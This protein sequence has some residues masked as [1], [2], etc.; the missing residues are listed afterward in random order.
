VRIGYLLF[1]APASCV[2]AINLFAGLGKDFH[3][4]EQRVVWVTGAGVAI[5]SA[6]GSIAGGYI[7]DRMNRGVL[8][9]LGGAAAGLC[10]LT[11]AFTL[12]TQAAFTAG[13]LV[14]NGLAGICYAAF[15]ALSLQLVGPNNPTA[16]TQL[17]LFA[18]C[19]NAAVVYMTWAD[20]QGYRLFA[21]RGLFLVDG[22]AAIGAA[23][24]LLLILRSRAKRTSASIDTAVVIP[25]ESLNL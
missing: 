6:I 21:V 24:P 4:G 5:S 14:Y 12:H 18:A 16:A 13:V 17:G 1:L 9:M 7:A 3:A 19:S 2:A 20:G 8:Y 11:M 15:T 23:I 25:Q 22:L 10:A